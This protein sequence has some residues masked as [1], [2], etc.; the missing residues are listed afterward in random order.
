MFKSQKTPGLPFI[1]LQHNRPVSFPRNGMWQTNEPYH[2]FSTILTNFDESE[3]LRPVI[4]LYFAVLTQ[5]KLDLIPE[6][7]FAVLTTIY[8]SHNTKK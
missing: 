6:T 2:A 8:H 3:N 7:E 5:E 4:Y 1:A